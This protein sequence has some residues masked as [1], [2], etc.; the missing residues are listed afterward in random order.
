[1]VIGVILHEYAAHI[2]EMAFF[3]HIVVTGHHHTEGQFLVVTDIVLLL[4]VLPFLLS[5]GRV[6]SLYLLLVH[7]E[8]PSLHCLDLNT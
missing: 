3:G 1:M 7:R 6:L 4:V 8:M 2:F 5:Y